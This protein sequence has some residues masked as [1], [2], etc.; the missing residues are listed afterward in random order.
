MSA[1]V[2]AVARLAAAGAVAGAACVGWGAGVE[3]E[4]YVLRHATA[5]ALRPAARGVLRVL[6]VSDL[7]LLPGQ[8]RVQ[9][10]L[11]AAGDLGHDLV[12]ATGDLLGS[13]ESVDEA[14]DLLV[15]LRGDRP[16]L[17]V[18]G[19]NDRY[20][21]MPLDLRKYFAPG[22]RP[23]LRRHGPPLDVDR[24]TK[25]L[26]DGGWQLADN[27]RLTVATRAGEIDVAGLGD[28]HIDLDDPTLVDWAAPG[29]AAPALRLGV[30]HAPYLRALDALER[31][32]A[33]L[34]LAGH[35]HGGQVR[36]PGIGALSSNCDLPVGRA[37]GLSRAGQGAWLHVS[38]GLG[39]ARTA[40]FRF[41]CRPEATLLDVVA[42]AQDSVVGSAPR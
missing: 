17:A 30:V 7:H 20:G 38:A 35:T 4:W 11:D 16:G 10:F 36:L 9:R 27:R 3:R 19:S 22:P 15:R 42:P 28:P 12:V 34:V 5:P 26:E 39:H 40:P 2:R 37:R 6:H 41:A 14:V 32:G 21:P 31:H 13:A 33:D 29:P 18:L 24:L 1:A 8:R 25:G 23:A